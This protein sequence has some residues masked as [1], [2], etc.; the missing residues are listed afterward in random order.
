MLAL[1][2]QA[3]ISDERRTVFDELAR[4]ETKKD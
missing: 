2:S 3:L 1:S 4:R